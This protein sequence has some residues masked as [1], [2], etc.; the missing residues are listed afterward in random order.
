M[1]RWPDLIT[2]TIST[3]EF[4]NGTLSGI[5]AKSDKTLI[6]EEDR[7]LILIRLIGYYLL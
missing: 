3:I 6:E 5:L 4:T 1:S 7:A 2:I